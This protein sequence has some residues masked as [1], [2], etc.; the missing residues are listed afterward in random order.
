MMKKKLPSGLNANMF[1]IFF[2]N[3]NRFL[4]QYINR[5]ASPSEINMFSNADEKFNEGN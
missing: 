5:V 3:K 1:L 4:M 2:G